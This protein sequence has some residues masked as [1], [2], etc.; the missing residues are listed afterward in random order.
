MADRIGRAQWPVALWGVVGFL[1]GF[2]VVAILS[3]GIFVLAAALLLAV[4]GLV[5][6]A[7]RTPAM[8]ALV[9]GLGIMPL[10]VAIWN[11]G[12]PGERCETT[13]SSVS[14]AG[15]LNPWPFA[16]P[17]A[18]LFVGGIWLVWQYASVDASR[19]PTDPS[20]LRM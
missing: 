3:I 14:C 11:W 8:L 13:G 7:S 16:I 5:H 19:I 4:F 9:P 6:P 20:D 17:G 12:G 2:G 18:I 1:I 10:S 15:L